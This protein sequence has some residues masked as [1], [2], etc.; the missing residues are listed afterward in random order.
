M[1]RVTYCVGAG[2]NFAAVGSDVPV[3][4]DEAIFGHAAALAELGI[5]LR[6]YSQ[7]NGFLYILDIKKKKVLKEIAP[8]GG[9]WGVFSRDGNAFAHVAGGVVTVLRCDMGTCLEVADTAGH[10]DMGFTPDS[11]AFF[12]GY[13]DRMTHRDLTTNSTTV[14]SYAGEVAIAGDTVFSPDGY[15]FVVRTPEK[16]LVYAIVDNTSQCARLERASP[17]WVK[18]SPDGKQVALFWDDDRCAIVSLEPNG[19]KILRISHIEG[20]YPGGANME[21]HNAD[22]AFNLYS[23]DSNRIAVCTSGCNAVNICTLD[24]KKLVVRLDPVVER[25]TGVLFA[26]RGEWVAIAH[27]SKVQLVNC[28]TR[29]CFPMD[30]LPASP[31]TIAFGADGGSFQVLQ[32]RGVSWRVTGLASDDPSFDRG[33]SDLVSEYGPHPL[34]FVC[35]DLIAVGSADLSSIGTYLT[36]E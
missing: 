25:I 4:H 1:A 12:V 21:G 33:E 11:K 15:S 3:E 17:N 27:A 30:V 2:G 5:E 13:P 8:K 31:S 22:S 24:T 18:Y 14:V 23:P 26:P 10:T 32:D 29:K 35:A 19:E 7:T 28:A 36:H 20:F 9:H 34:K 16:T 6:T